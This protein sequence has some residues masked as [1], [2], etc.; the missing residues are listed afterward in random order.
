MKRL[1]SLRFPMLTV[2]LAAVVSAGSWR[3]LQAQSEVQSG[4]DVVEQ[5]CA[6]CHATGANGA[7]RIGDVDAW[8]AR[9]SAGL[10]S[11]TK[12]ALEGIRQMPAHGGQPGLSDLDIA[13]AITY[14]VNQSGGNWVAPVTRSDIMRERT[15]EQVV[16]AVCTECHKEGKNGAPR[17][18]DK[19]AW[20]LRLRQGLSYAVRSAI[21]G[22]GGMPPRGGVA[23]LTDAEIRNAILY[24]LNPQVSVSTEIPATPMETRSAPAG[25]SHVTVGGVDVYLG[26]ISTESLR[27]Y[28]PES[29]ERSM[30]GGVP[31]GKNW[32]HLNVSLLDK[33]TQA[34]IEHAQVRASVGEVGSNGETKQ[35]EAMDIGQGSYGEYFRMTPHTSYSVTLLVRAPGSAGPVEAQFRYETQ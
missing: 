11:L 12:H 15:G 35:L 26:L 25:S 21:H 7:P 32:Y 16:K 9:A 33:S 1:P 5:V 13:R 10:T 3:D 22:H 31:S 28:P 23:S 2:V 30:H 4:K 34:P 24:M 19:G 8:S 27:A 18:G 14:M 20:A 6:A 29:A 17:I